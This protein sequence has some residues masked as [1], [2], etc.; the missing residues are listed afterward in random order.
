M[1]SSAPTALARAVALR[2][3][4]SAV[5]EPSVPTTILVGTPLSDCPLMVGPSG[6]ARTR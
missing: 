1:I 2:T 6:S 3:A 5:S 4:R